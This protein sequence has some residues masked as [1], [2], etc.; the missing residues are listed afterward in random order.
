MTETM[1]R[2][3]R[4]ELVMRG[5]FWLKEAREVRG[6]ACVAHAEGKAEAYVAAALLVERI[7]L[8]GETAALTAQN[9]LA[10][11]TGRRY[12]EPAPGSDE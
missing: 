12:G 1:A 10:D 7:A 9:E 2:A 6:D 3:I 5:R 4:D 11:Y 8:P